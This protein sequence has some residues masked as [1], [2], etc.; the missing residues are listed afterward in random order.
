M[1]K[2]LVKSLTKYISKSRRQ[3]TILFT[4]IEDSTRYWGNRGDVEGR[5]M[6]DRHNRIIFPII[7]HFNGKVIKTIGDSIMASFKQ[8]SDALNAS[9]AIQQSLENT[10]KTDRNF[11]IHVRIGLHS[12][13]AL[14]EYNDVYG[15]VVN[16]AARVESQ[17]DGDQILISGQLAKSL[18]QQHFTYHKKGGFIPKGKDKR[19]ALYLCNWRK[20]PDL[21]QRIKLPPFNPLEPRQIIETI[22]SIIAAI[23][24]LNFLHH[25]YLRYM[26][27]DREKMSIFLLNPI[28][29]Q[30]SYWGPSLILVIAILL[31]IVNASKNKTVPYRS[32]KLLKGFAAGGLLF[33]L[34]YNLHPMIPANLNADYFKI[35]IYSSRHLF[36]EIQEDNSPIHKDPDINSPVILRPLAKTLLLLS[37]VK[38]NKKQLWNKVLVGKYK[39]GWVQRIRP[40]QIGLAA[41]RIT[42]AQKFYL[43]HWDIFILLLS[44]P[45]FIWGYRSFHMRPT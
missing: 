23:Y 10:R 42:W 9:I 17:A 7:R 21:L 2:S 6:V 12:G 38:R 27:A 30:A 13:T 40:A 37:D 16:V 15:D 39:Y 43:R 20:H 33:T 1:Q 34:L 4:D 19:I 36:V 8:S 41:T 32:L 3:V 45:G 11:R 14:V 25:H 22:F 35:K 44:F 18:N 5:L 28:V 31:V 26:L 29:M 24:T